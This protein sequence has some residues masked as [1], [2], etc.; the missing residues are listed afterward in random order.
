MKKEILF[1]GIVIDESTIFFGEWFYGDLIQ[2]VD[3]TVYIRQVQ[4]NSMLQVHPETVCQF[5]GLLDKNGNK[6]FE[7]DKIN[8][9]SNYEYTIIFNDY[10]FSAVHNSLIDH[11]NL[12]LIWGKIHRFNECGIEIEIIGNIHD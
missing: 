7:G 4:T 2:Y 5:T 6:I 8:G 10:S 11:E 3:G 1:K 12:P 9:N